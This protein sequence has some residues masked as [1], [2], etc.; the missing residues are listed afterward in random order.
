MYFFPSLFFFF[1]WPKKMR[2]KVTQLCPTLC[3][4]MDCRPPGSSDHG[5]HPEHC[6]GWLFPSPGD[7]PN[8]GIEFSNYKYQ[9]TLVQK[10]NL[11]GN[12]VTVGQVGTYTIAHLQNF[13]I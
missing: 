11:P 12:C 13:K 7:P 2:M 3:D 4:P 5:I 8:P 10:S 6:S 1:F 9:K